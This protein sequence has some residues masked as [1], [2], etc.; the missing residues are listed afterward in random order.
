ML[1]PVI[2][3]HA[4]SSE[5]AVAELR[6][7]D[8]RAHLVRFAAWRC[9]SVDGANDLVA[10]A[11]LLVCD[12]ERKP[13]DPAKGSFA[14]HVRL[15]I[16]DLVVERARTGPGRFESPEDGL[17]EQESTP[18]GARSPEDALRSERELEWMRELAERTL[19]RTERTY[20]H[21]RAIFG[22][23]SQGFDRPS[24]WVHEIGC[25]LEQAYATIEALKRHGRQVR[26]DWERS[27]RARM[28]NIP[29]QGTDR[30]AR[31]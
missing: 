25:P 14:R 18:D 6:K 3:F 2:D 20:P 31:G 17:P 21:A 5:R 7:D 27:E 28:R 13:W 1:A 4:S 11:M 19:G 26:A 8:V 23:L 29:P 9:A 16:E 12:P 22:R 24:E 15:V 30:E 10:D